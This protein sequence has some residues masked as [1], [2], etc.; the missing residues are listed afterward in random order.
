MYFDKSSNLRLDFNDLLI[1][2]ADTT[3]ISSRKEV[4]PFMPSGFLPIITAPMDTVVDW[5]N[6]DMYLQN[7]I[8]V[9]LPRI[10]GGYIPSTDFNEFHS[11]SLDEF[12][13]NYIGIGELPNSIHYVLI[14]IANGHM[15][16]M[17]NAVTLAKKIHG[18]KL[19][20]MAGNV[21]SPE[22]YH[23]LSNAGADAVRI[24]IGNGNGCLT[25]QQTGVGF[26]MASLIRECHY[27]AEMMLEHKALIVADGGMKN[28]ADIIKAIALGAD[29]VMVGSVLNKCLESCGETRIFKYFPVSPQSNFAHWAFKK[30]FRLTK[31]FRGMSTKEVQKSW[32]NESIKTSEGV[33]R[34]RPVEYTLKQW[35][36]NFEDYLRSTMSYT[37]CKTLNDF[38]GKVKLNT[39]SEQAFKRFTK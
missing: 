15:R 5:D 36:D 16:K 31:R 38:K 28:Y 13:S 23:A 24:G 20:I 11:L 33:V 7:K 29:L 25:S 22:A 4:N 14:D 34:I 30:G 1:K 32:G 2:P 26:P 6:A 12:I 21:A 10:R 8:N 37:N 18:N 35:V 19:F 3:D 17:L 27:K 9:C 39:I